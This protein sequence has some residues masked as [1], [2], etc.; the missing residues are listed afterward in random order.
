[1]TETL[2]AA[3]ESLA[4]SRGTEGNKLTETVAGHLAR[5]AALAEAAE[6]SA[7]AQPDALKR[8]REQ[9]AAL[10]RR[11]RICRRIA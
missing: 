4:V 11:S 6:R 9:V 2:E 7:S 3:L 10:W 5:I 8:L 1:M